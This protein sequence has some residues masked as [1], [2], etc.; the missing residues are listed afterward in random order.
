M[1]HLTGVTQ[2]THQR[3]CKHRYT[4][5]QIR[6]TG[7]VTGGFLQS[8][9]PPPAHLHTRGRPAELFSLLGWLSWYKGRRSVAVA[10]FKRALESQSGHCLTV[11]LNEM[12]RTGALLAVSKNP[13]TAYNS[14]VQ[15]ES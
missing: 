9:A 12:L 4:D 7:L 8:T 1:T 3:F 5:T 6:G 2:C 14:P 10:Y 13:A 15:S 11:L